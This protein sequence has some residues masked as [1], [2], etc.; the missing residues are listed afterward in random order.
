[1][2]DIENYFDQGEPLPSYSGITINEWNGEHPIVEYIVISKGIVTASSYYGFFYSK[3]DVPVSF[4][5]SRYGVVKTS[6]TE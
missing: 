5:N 3:D 1:I 2:N 6:H 4:Q